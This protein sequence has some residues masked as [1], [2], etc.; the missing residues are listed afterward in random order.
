MGE[1]LTEA[2]RRRTDAAML[3]SLAG[4]FRILNDGGPF[5]CS[6]NF[7]DVSLL[8]DR[9]AELIKPGPVAALSR[10]GEGK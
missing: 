8:L 2:Q 1:N 5:V 10:H 6:F 4:T 9:V 3:E 7:E